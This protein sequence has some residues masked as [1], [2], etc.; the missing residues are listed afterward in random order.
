MISHH[1]QTNFSGQMSE[2]LGINKHGDKEKEV[3]LQTSAIALY[4]SVLHHSQ[5]LSDQEPNKENHKSTLSN[6]VKKG[7][8]IKRTDIC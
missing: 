7:W 5:T 4:G 1:R 8:C 2:K 6:K 3:F